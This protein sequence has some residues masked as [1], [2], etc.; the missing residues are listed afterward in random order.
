MYLSH[1]NLIEKPFRINPDPRFLWLGEKHREALAIL[2]YGVLDKHG[3]LLLTGEVGTGKTTLI[4]ALVNDL[5]NDTIVANVPNPQ[6]E[7]IEFFNFIAA[8][9]RIRKRFTNKFDFLKTFSHYLHKFRE[10]N[11][12]LLLIIDEAQRI[13]PDL[14]EEIRLLSNI[15]KQDTKLLNIFFVGQNEFNDLLR[16]QDCRALRQRITLTYNINLLTHE[17]TKEY[18]RYRLKVAGNV[19][20]VFT[21]KAIHQI[22]K[23]SRGIPRLINIMCDRALLT[24]YVKDV[25]TIKP[26]IIKECAKELSLP[27]ETEQATVQAVARSGMKKYGRRARAVLYGFLLILLILSGYLIFLGSHKDYL[28]TVQN[29]GVIVLEKLGISSAP[30]YS[31]KDK[32]RKPVRDLAPTTRRP[33]QKSYPVTPE[34]SGNPKHIEKASAALESSKTNPEEQTISLNDLELVFRFG[35][36]NNELAPETQDELDK[37]AKVMLKQPEMKIVVKGYTDTLGGPEYNRKLSEFRANVVK[38]YLVGKGIS[39]TRIGALGMGEKNPVEPNTTAGG[40]QANRRVEIEITAHV[41]EQ[42]ASSNGHGA[43]DMAPGGSSRMN[44]PRPPDP[45]IAEGSAS[46]ETT[47]DKAAGEQN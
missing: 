18:V 11:K 41:T 37:L 26:S 24:G 20:E 36:N 45:A 9:F 23:Y 35:Y 31:R 34:V 4:N 27:G 38:A 46:V 10:Y 1:Y 30:S 44:P 43:R 7:T 39:S 6:L 47:A 5:G 17:E 16:T 33:E 13:P 15:E 2:R 29:Y 28:A 8:A 3:F 40:R 14:L 19:Q 12:N 42:G 22:Y 32:I 21:L 25:K